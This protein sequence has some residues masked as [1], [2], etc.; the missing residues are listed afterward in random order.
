MRIVL[1]GYGN[2]ARKHMDVFRALQCEVVAS[3]NRSEVNNR[4]AMSEGKVPRTYTNYMEMVETEKPDAI[5]NCSSFDNIYA[6][7]KD[8]MPFGI[9]M[10]IEKPAG[11]S[12]TELQDLIEIQ[13]KYGT[14]VQV[15]LNRRHYS[16]F[17]KAMV[18]AGGIENIRMISVEWSENP[19]KV[20]KSR[21]Y[22][23]A[24]LA[25]LLY[26][27]SI[28]G[29]DMLNW[30]SGGINDF[31]IVTKKG[32]GF[33]DWS[34]VLSGISK[35]GI[36]VNFTSSW[37]SPVPWRMIFYSEGRRHEFAPLETCR[38]Y[39]ASAKDAYEIFPDQ[40]DFDF[41]A[42]FYSQILN[43]IK[44][45]NSYERKSTHDLQSSLNSMRLV[46][47]LFLDLVND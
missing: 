15:A 45:Q 12:V 31:E 2:I 1:I 5:L 33:F 28:H 4:K 42:G 41:K 40:F 26:G 47:A 30:F 8:L 14:N 38:V 22:T 7:T 46:E 25:R 11:T 29:L 9:P 39:D 27:N 34:M 44:T 37:S 32:E 13:S 23:D 3:C 19:S 24:Q 16:V 20:K 36:L 6:T 18:D 35:T 21:G 17:N 10:L 43:F